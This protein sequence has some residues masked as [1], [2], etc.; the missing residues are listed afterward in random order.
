MYRYHDVTQLSSHS[1]YQVD[2]NLI[3][4]LDDFL[5]AGLLSMLINTTTNPSVIPYMKE[6]GGYF[7]VTIEKMQ[8]ELRINE[9]K[10]RT[11]LRHLEELGLISLANFG[12]PCRRHIKVEGGAI[13]EF[14]NRY[15]ASVEREDVAA[16]IEEQSKDEYYD[17]LNEAIFKGEE[18]Y[19]ES[20]GNMA[21]RFAAPLYVFTRA[22]YLY[23][24]IV[25]EWDPVTYGKFKN[26][27]GMKAVDYQ[28]LVNIL[29][30][31]S[32]ATASNIV[33]NF[34]LLNKKTVE[35]SPDDRIMKPASLAIW[36]QISGATTL[37]KVTN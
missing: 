19:I 21:P 11:A 27:L 31:D 33:W 12:I 29:Q 8:E 18:E 37:Q 5:L 17:N 22:L 15:L 14:L 32:F 36:P 30:D 4:A 1:F 28:R 26:T 35:Q 20:I 13:C 16:V 6:N 25:V 3:A 7:F 23:H 34:K 24:G 9:K 2:K 10:Q